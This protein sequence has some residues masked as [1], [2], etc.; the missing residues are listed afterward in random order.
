MKRFAQFA[1]STYVNEDTEKLFI[2]IALNSALRNGD[3][4]LKNFGVVYDD[5][6]GE[7]RLAPVYDLV[8][9]SVYL[10]KD[11]LALTLNGSTGWP[12]AK[13]LRKLGE[14]R[15]GGTPARI[16]QVLGRIAEAIQETTGEVRAY[17]KEH[18]E[19]VEIG[20]RMLQEWENGVNT[21]LR[22]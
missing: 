18:P 7:A 9:T 12:T 22:G 1:N 10:P 15:G 17:M 13:E 20:Q 14:T 3:A 16:R 21:S 5:V 8:T 6:Q 19:F 11:S 4:H 2:L